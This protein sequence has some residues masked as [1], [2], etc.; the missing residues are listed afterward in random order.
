MLDLSYLLSLFLLPV[1]SLIITVG[2]FSVFQE[3]FTYS[4]FK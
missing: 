1:L 3:Y 4:F 2:V